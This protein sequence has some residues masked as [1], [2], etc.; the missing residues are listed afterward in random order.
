M[1]V[2]WPESSTH[3]INGLSRGTLGEI[4]APLQNDIPNFV[5]PYFH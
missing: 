3:G 4:N 1:N 2:S 5:I